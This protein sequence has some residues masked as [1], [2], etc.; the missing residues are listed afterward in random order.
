MPL[1]RNIRLEGPGLQ[2]PPGQ[3]VASY[4]FMARQEPAWSDLAQR[5]QAEGSNP[6]LQLTQAMA[7][8]CIVK[9]AAGPRVA[10]S[11]AACL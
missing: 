10:F 6:E 4:C 8:A 9:A 7:F 5:S 11:A 2:E 3:W 1:G